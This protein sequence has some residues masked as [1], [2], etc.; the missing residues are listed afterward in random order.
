MDF[1]PVPEIR[2][3]NTATMLRHIFLVILIQGDE[4]ISPLLIGKNQHGYVVDKESTH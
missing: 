4:L 1:L 3:L 2:I